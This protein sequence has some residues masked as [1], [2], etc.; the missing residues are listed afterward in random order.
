MFHRLFLVLCLLLTAA[1]TLAQEDCGLEGRIM[2]RR[3]GVVV[4]DRPINVRAEPSFNAEI[5]NTLPNDGTVFQV[6]PDSE[7]VCA[8]GARW[9]NVSEYPYGW[10]AESV[11]DEYVVAPYVFEPAPPVDFD[12]PL[13][14]PQISDL[15]TPLPTI[16][17]ASMPEA[18][19]PAFVA[20]FDWSA[21]I[22]D[23]Y[24]YELGAPNP[25][26]LNMPNAYN[27][28]LPVPPVDLSEVYFVADANLNEQQLTLLAQNGFVVV[29]SGLQQFDTA[30]RSFESAWDHTEGK[31]DFITTDALLHTLFLVYQ[32]TQM[33]LEMGELYGDAAQI[34]MGG[35]EQ[36]LT[37][38]Q[39][40]QGTAL[41]EPARRAAVYYAVALG[42]L[43]QGQDF[44]T[45]PDPNN[46]G[47]ELPYY[48]ESTPSP[49]RVL[50]S[51][52]PDIIAA[53][54]PI[55][56]M[57]LAAQGRLSV[58]ILTDYDEDFSQYQPRSYYNSSPLLQ[59]YFR[60][61][62]W[63]GRITF[64][65]ESPEDTQTGLLV[66]RALLQDE[67]AHAAYERMS[68]LLD[69]LVGPVDDLSPAD[70]TPLARE[71]YGDDLTLDAIASEGNLQA[72]LDEAQQLP[73]PRVNSIPIG[74]GALTPE[75][76]AEQTRGFR[77]FGQRFTFDGYAMQQLVYPEVGTAANSRTLPLGLDVPAVLGSDM[78]YTL[79]DDMGAT[80]YLNYTENLSALREETNTATGSDWLQNLSGA[81]LW[82]LQP[83]AFR[84]PAVIP[85]MMQTDAWLRKDLSTFLGSWTQLKHATLLYAEQPMGGLG[86]GGM[87]PPVISYSYVEPQPQ[88]FA[89]IALISA[90]LNQG[91]A[92]RGYL[93]DAY[94]PMYSIRNA[95]VALSVLAA[96]LAEM[97]R[98]EIAGEPLTYDELYFLQEQFAQAYWYIRY[99]IEVWITDP[100]ENTALVADVASNAASGQVLHV[101]IA[102]P[103]YIYVITNSPYGYTL[104]RGAVYSY[105]E[106]IS[107]IDERLTD[108]AW[109]ALVAAGEIPPRPDW[110]GLYFAE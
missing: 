41:E 56:D 40:A 53:A 17:P 59:A 82:T 12:I 35:F 92:E 49:R 18:I 22:G 57:A 74:E 6:L 61:M 73:L 66:L 65:T 21:F 83:L 108:E 33:F 107:P 90:L 87:E 84:D 105:Y 10:I 45:Y 27:G 100:P 78:A 36:A 64:F 67:A 101:A 58:P 68:S 32:N 2:P 72:F 9:L 37:Q 80:E 79:T 39:A 15:T 42:L 77:L 94:T 28:D 20:D 46:F 95:S 88:V 7:P 106:F 24:T 103:D 96:N 85:P 110:I 52:D 54:Q 4:A 104:T 60:A 63:L 19:D 23:S 93:P 43:A 31:G 97:A 5:V 71:I 16:T 76:L 51:A 1:P 26:T 102:E 89:R 34:L 70:Y 50:E 99:E 11:Y 62:M 30:Y 69:F 3:H 98:K 109:R 25:L 44:Y 47:Q 75:Q 91:L 55:I 13:N 38:Y 48:T 86:G 29:P 14:E 81:W 8:E